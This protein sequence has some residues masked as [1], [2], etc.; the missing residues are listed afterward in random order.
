MKGVKNILDHM[1]SSVNLIPG[2][3]LEFRW[4]YKEPP[5]HGV[6]ELKDL[7]YIARKLSAVNWVDVL[8]QRTKVVYIVKFSINC[9][10]DDFND[11]MG[12]IRERMFKNEY[13]KS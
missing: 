7:K 13:T 9:T 6:Y 8:I 4:F 11:K 1:Q 10:V 5:K 12:L 3:S 2:I